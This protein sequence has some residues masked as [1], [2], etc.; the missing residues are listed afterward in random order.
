MSDARP[1]RG[2]V[3]VGA[4]TYVGEPDDLW[5]HK[6]AYDALVAKHAEEEAA[7]RANHDSLVA[8][9]RE[10]EREKEAA[11]GLQQGTAEIAKTYKSRYRHLV[12]LLRRDGYWAALM[13]DEEID[14]QVDE[15]MR[16]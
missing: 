12:E 16:K 9:I 3:F 14:A 5:I 7:W 1:V 10:L 8:S 13:T 2:M 11:R 4:G 6:N 15:D